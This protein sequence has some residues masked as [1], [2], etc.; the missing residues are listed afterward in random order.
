M[1]DELRMDAYYFGFDATGCRDVDLIL[2]AVASAGKAYHHTSDWTEELPHH[3]HYDGNTPAGWV[4]SSAA[5]AAARIESLTAERDALREA[6]TT[7]PTDEALASACMWYRHDFGLLDK[8][9]QRE[10]IA[11]AR[12]WWRASVKEIRARALA[13]Q[14]GAKG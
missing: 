4:Q 8:E 7:E 6:L 14:E 5:K 11:V 2:S 12:E 9:A 3:P 1:S 13:Q 10:W